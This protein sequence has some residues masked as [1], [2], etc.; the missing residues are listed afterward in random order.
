MTVAHTFIITP[1][2]IN[3]LR[4]GLVGAAKPHQARHEVRGYRGQAG[5]HGSSTGIAE[6]KRFA[7][8][9]HYRV[10][11]DGPKHIALAQHDE[12]RFWTA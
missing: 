10:S 8:V 12:F 11:R 5:N 1:T 6:F 3:E 4:G 2:L 9:H 7:D